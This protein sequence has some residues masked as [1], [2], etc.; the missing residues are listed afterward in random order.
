M[1]ERRRILGP[2]AVTDTIITSQV[3]G[4]FGGSDDVVNRDRVLRMRQ[5]D[6]DNV[7]AQIAISFD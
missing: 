5:I 6:V 1:L 4:G 7:R 2:K 3:R